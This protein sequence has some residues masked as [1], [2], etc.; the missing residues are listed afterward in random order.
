MTFLPAEYDFKEERRMN[1]FL[2]SSYGFIFASPYIHIGFC[3]YTFL[4]V[5]RIFTEAAIFPS[6]DR[7]YWL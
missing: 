4:A 1:A 7:P 3:M 6:S 5:V 2:V